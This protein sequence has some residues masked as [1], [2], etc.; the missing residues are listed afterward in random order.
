MK[1]FCIITAELSDLP[2]AAEVLAAV[3]AKIKQKRRN[4]SP[5]TNINYKILSD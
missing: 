3:A 5:E 4:M 1:D 2:R